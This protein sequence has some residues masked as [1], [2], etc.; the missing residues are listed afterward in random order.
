MTS[1]ELHE[2]LSEFIGV[3]VRITSN[4]TSSEA[5]WRDSYPELVEVIQRDVDEAVCCKTSDGVWSVVVEDGLRIDLE[6]AVG[7]FDFSKPAIQMEMIGTALHAYKT[8]ESEDTPI[9]SRDKPKRLDWSE[10]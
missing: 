10:W 2:K 3:R 5:I 8:T 4:A 1:K 6:P 7:T 9:N